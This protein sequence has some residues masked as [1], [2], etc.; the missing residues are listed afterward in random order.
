VF[1]AQL[2]SRRS[3]DCGSPRQR[4]RENQAVAASPDARHYGGKGEDNVVKIRDTLVAREVRINGA[5]VGGDRNV[6]E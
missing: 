5:M 3:G 1:R 4:L 6:M 2:C